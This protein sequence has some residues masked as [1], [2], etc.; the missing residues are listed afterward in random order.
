MTG[1]EAPF[2]VSDANNTC[3]KEDAMRSAIPKTGAWYAELA[4]AAAVAA[5]TA[6]V[7]QAQEDFQARSWAA[8]CAGC[9]GTEGRSQGA[10]P[11]LAGRPKDEILRAMLDFKADR[12]SASVMHQHAKGYSDNQLERMAEYFSKQKK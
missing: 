4:L 3:E 5:S 11:P 7:A 6:S 10:I 12:R 8:S 1:A 9:H 2:F